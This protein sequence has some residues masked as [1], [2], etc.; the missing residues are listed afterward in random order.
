MGAAWR[1]KTANTTHAKP[2][3]KSASNISDTNDNGESKM[4]QFGPSAKEGTSAEPG[5]G[6]FA[7]IK[8]TINPGEGTTAANQAAIA[9][10]KGCFPN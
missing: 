5:E 7:A 3:A 9:Q 1:H 10:I 8:A 4:L 2:D 6:A